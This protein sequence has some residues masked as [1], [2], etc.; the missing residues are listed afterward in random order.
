[1]Q[2]RHIAEGEITDIIKLQGADDLDE[3]YCEL[4]WYGKGE[5]EPSA[6][7]GLM[8]V[9]DGWKWLTKYSNHK[10][11]SPSIMWCRLCCDIYS[12]LMKR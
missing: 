8:S 9:D 4:V 2:V 11:K 5:V 10:K 1:M 3:D 12:P 6:T 7:M